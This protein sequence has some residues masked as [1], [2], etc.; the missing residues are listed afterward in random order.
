MNDNLSGREL[1]IAVAKAMGLNVVALDWPCSHDPEC[2]SYYAE[3]DRV[4]RYDPHVEVVPDAVYL[5]ELGIWPPDEDGQAIVEP[6]PFYSTDPARLVEMFDWLHSQEWHISIVAMLRDSPRCSVWQRQPFSRMSSH[7][8]SLPEAVARVV[9]AVGKAREE[10]HR[11][12]V[13]PDVFEALDPQ[14]IAG[15]SQKAVLKFIAAQTDNTLVVAHAEKLMKAAGVFGNPEHAD[16]AVYSTI[17]RSPEF[18]K[19]DR[20]VYR[21]IEVPPK[22][23]ARRDRTD[24]GLRRLVKSLKEKNPALT[25]D[26]VQEELVKGGFDFRGKRPLSAINMAWVA[27]GY[28]KRRLPK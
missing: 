22:L 12:T 16:S 19:V 7:G 6:V 26:Q 25:R 9:V 13:S 27:L 18:V 24:S 15:M 4:G 14:V 11:G 23:A 1:D 8:R 10:G 5:P 3:Q 20:G 28:G 21:V 17:L 2:G